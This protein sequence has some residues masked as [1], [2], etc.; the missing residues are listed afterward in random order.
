MHLPA[1][2]N[3]SLHQFMNGLHYIYHT[4]SSI[5]PFMPCT[6]TFVSTLESLLCWLCL[7]VRPWVIQEASCPD[8]LLLL[9][10][11]WNQNVRMQDPAKKLGGKQWTHCEMFRIFCD[12]RSRFVSFEDYCVIDNRAE[13]WRDFE[14][15]KI[16]DVLSNILHLRIRGQT[17]GLKSYLKQN[18]IPDPTG[19]NYCS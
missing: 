9:L 7:E 15:A 6:A 3:N 16:R 5:H 8:H 17:F 11:T 2:E 10:L 4:M 19:S 1:A 18:E 14:Q 13:M 12:A